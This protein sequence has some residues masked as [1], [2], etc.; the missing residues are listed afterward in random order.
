MPLGARKD[1]VQRLQLS[2]AK[3][4]ICSAIGVAEY[5]VHAHCVLSERPQVA[6]EEEQAA[7]GLQH[8]MDFT[9]CFPSTEVVDRRTRE[10]EVEDRVLK[11]Q[12]LRRNC[13]KEHSTLPCPP[14]RAQCC[15]Q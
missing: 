4:Q 12:P 2:P 11:R 9:K 6:L 3:R 1:A 5:P 14:A 13:V 10:S 15:A 7:T 8:P